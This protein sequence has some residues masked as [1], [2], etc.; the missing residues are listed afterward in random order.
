V[1]FDFDNTLISGDVGEAVLAV[2]AVSGRL[3]PDSISRTL[4]P[5]IHVQGRRKVEVHTCSD[6]MEYYEAFLSPTIHG[7]ADPAPL[8]NGYI[9][10]TQALENL[11]LAEVLAATAA[12][13]DIGQPEASGGIEVT[14]GQTNY[15]AP[16][17]HSEMVELLAELLRLGYS[18]W[19]VSASNIWAVRWMVI[20]GLNRLLA[21][22]GLTKGFP[23]RQVIGLATLLS[24]AQ[25]RLY[26][27][28]VLAREEPGYARLETPLLES[29]FVTRHVQFPAPVYSGKVACI[30]DALGHNPYLC[31]GDSPSDHPMLCLSRHRLWI[32]RPD[33]TE[34]QRSTRALLRRT[35]KAGWLFQR[36]S[37][38]TCAQIHGAL[39]S[40]RPK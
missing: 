10:A 27:D 21:Q 4:C 19:I 11:T 33:K 13:F 25:G 34:A 14:R 23:P 12:A 17:F 29:L 5:A 15:P 31:A 32:V 7:S 39:R 18:P 30:L 16:R 22:R 36:S 8:A 38:M 40:Q 9:W 26:K 1:V 6:I 3:K 37:T 35:G 2:L 20:H 24:D 28:S